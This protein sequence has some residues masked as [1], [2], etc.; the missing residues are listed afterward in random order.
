ME[1]MR[2][3]VLPQ[4]ALMMAHQPSSPNEFS[5]KSSPPFPIDESER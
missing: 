1:E 4:T 3:A 5:L 2:L